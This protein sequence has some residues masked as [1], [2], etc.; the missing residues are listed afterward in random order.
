MT[1]QNATMVDE[2]TTASRNLAEQAD[3]LMQLVE[4]FRL[5]PATGHRMGRAA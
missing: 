1:Q 4:Q 3:T 5:E 2:A